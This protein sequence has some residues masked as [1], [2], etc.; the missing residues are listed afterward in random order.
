MKIETVAIERCEMPLEDKDWK[1]ALRVKLVSALQ[2]TASSARMVLWP[3][4]T[5][6]PHVGS[7]FRLEVRTLKLVPCR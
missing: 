1:F 4:T 7:A 3:T 2:S 5:C 6:R